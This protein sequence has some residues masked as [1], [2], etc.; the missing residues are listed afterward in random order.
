MPKTNMRWRL[1]K[2]GLRRRTGGPPPSGAARGRARIPSISQGKAVDRDL[3]ATTVKRLIK[4]SAETACSERSEIDAFSGHS[5]RVGAAQ[6]LLCAGHDTAAI[7]RAGGWK[8]INVLARYFE[9]AEHNVWASEPPRMSLLHRVAAIAYD[10]GPESAMEPYLCDKVRQIS[11]LN[12][13]AVIDR[14]FRDMELCRVIRS[15]QLDMCGVASI[16]DG[17]NTSVASQIGLV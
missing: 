2:K 15:V 10:F 8:S 13:N 5:L 9:Y 12:Q 16:G 11:I 14:I 6:D 7:M 3:S 17:E 1:S 4:T